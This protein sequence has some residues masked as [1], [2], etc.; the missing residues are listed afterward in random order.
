MLSAAGVTAALVCAVIG[1]GIP[2]FLLFVTSE[3]GLLF[4]T[5]ATALTIREFPSQPP[6]VD[7]VAMLKVAI[8][9]LYPPATTVLDGIQHAVL[10]AG[11]VFEDLCVSVFILL[12][13]MALLHLMAPET[14]YHRYST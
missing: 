13:T 3:L 14:L 6:V 11:T 4:W 7:T 9:L 2:C 12:V 5:L 8:G 10:L 1:Y